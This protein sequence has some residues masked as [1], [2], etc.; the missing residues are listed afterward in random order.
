MIKTL[1]ILFLLCLIDQAGAAFSSLSS[2]PLSTFPSWYG[3]AVNLGNMDSTYTEYSGLTMGQRIENRGYLWAI[4]DGSTAYLIAISSTN[5]SSQGQ[6]NLSGVTTSDVESLTS[7]TYK[8]QPY[9]IVGDTGDNANARSNFRL[10]RV[11]EPQIFGT[12]F[13]VDAGEIESIVC[14][15][16]SGDT[17]THKDVETIIGDPHTG[18]VYVITKRVSPVKCY[19]LNYADSYTGTN[20]LDDVGD[21]TSDG[22]FN[23]IS[24][25]VSGNNG[26]ATAGTIHPSGSQIVIRSYDT[27]WLFERNISTQTIIDALQGT[28]TAIDGF[29]GGGEGLRSLHPGMEPQGEAVTFGQSGWD[30]FTCSELVANRGSSS[31]NYPL[32]LIPRI[33]RVPTTYTFQQ[34]TDSYS[35]GVDTYIDSGAPTTDNGSGTTFICDYDWSA[36]PTPSRTRAGLV[37]WDISSIPSGSVV[38]DAFVNWYINT[39]GLG[40]EVYRVKVPWVSSSTWDSLTNGLSMDDVELGSTAEF[41]VGDLDVGQGWDTYT[42]PVQ[43]ALPVSLV[44]EWLDTPGTNFGLY[45]PGPV[46]SSGD[47]LQ[48]RSNDHATTTDRP[49]LTIRTIQP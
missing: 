24:T 15:F 27:L 17:P 28:P 33:D 49:K 9:I 25:T 23:T 6:F 42:G 18:N 32:F 19:R 36:F 35:G 47:G 43:T 8:G 37:Y 26:Y 46:E 16:P 4:E 22:D 7:Y 41:I 5:G 14:E 21:L 38:V 3:Q 2:S 45:M 11:K 30:L 20:T 1:S 29:A 44:Q 48:I 40:F 34:G 39:E 12:N 31:T 10:I 13:T